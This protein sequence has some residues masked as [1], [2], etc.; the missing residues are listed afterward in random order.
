MQILVVDDDELI[1]RSLKRLLKTDF[2]IVTAS[3]A[4][5]AFL[6]LTKNTFDVILCDVRMPGISG[7][8]FVAKLSPLDAE[9]VIFISGGPAPH[10]EGV[11]NPKCLQKPFTR[12][13]LYDALYEVCG[14]GRQAS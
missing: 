12:N 14:E 7:P 6:E 8:A 9:R 2:V 13:E 4:S 1:L 10:I 11:R 3:S 5:D